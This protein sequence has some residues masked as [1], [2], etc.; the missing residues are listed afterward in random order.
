[1]RSTQPTS[2]TTNYFHDKVVVITGSSAGLGLALAGAFVREFAKLIIIGRD[3]A[4]LE[5]AAAQLR[6]TSSNV[7]V[8]PADVTVTEDVARLFETVQHDFGRLDV[9]I[10]NVG[11]SQ[12]G[13]ASETS[14]QQFQ[15]LWEVNFLS[16]VRCTQAAIPM[17]TA[18]KGHL[19]NIG[20]LSAK[21][22]T[23][24]LG[25]YPASKFPLAA[26][27]QQLRLEL[28]DYGIHVLLVCPGPIHRDDAGE[29]YAE[30]ATGLPESAT[31]PGGGANLTAI[32]P[33]WLANRILDACRKRRPELVVPSK[34][35]WLFA[36]G[37]L[38]PSLGDWIVRKKTS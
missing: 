19:V 8:I 22:A 26:Y 15:E 27:S 20:S 14:P 18:S 33:N 3:V 23:P 32:D 30:Q 24:L 9:L 1:M 5:Q 35:R 13:K 28:T 31:R 25:A 10:N 6:A 21:V 37:Q 2:G 11:R 12:R 34:A 7:S 17:L 36:V 29:R 16:A 38:W 4:K